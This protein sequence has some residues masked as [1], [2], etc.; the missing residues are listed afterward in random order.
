M[1]FDD[2]ETKLRDGVKMM[3]LCSPHNP[4][5]RVWTAEELLR[6][7]ELCSKYGVLIISD[8]IH[9]D[10]IY[11]SYR[12]IPIASLPGTASGNI[13]TCVS[14]TK[15]FNM[16]G[17]V[18]SFAI[19]PDRKMKKLFEEELERTGAGMNNIFGMIG[20]EAAFR[21]SEGWLEDLLVYLQENLDLVLQFF[22][23]RVRSIRVFKPES[24][25]LVWMDC[26]EL[27]MDVPA[28]KEFF[29]H[30]A[31]V[32]LNEGT[33]FGIDGTGF[34]RMNI[35]CPRPVLLEGLTRIESAIDMMSV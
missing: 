4:V 27:G 29:I 11:K 22:E 25:Y 34:M 13:I 3:I 32:G 23:E 7:T 30:Q 5:G 18:S 26:R 24:T 12:H 10:L 28:L 20:G 19:I 6:V 9:S 33:T 14:P 8:E 21:Y 17:L 15:T 35:A 16:A 31:G 1:D 2:L